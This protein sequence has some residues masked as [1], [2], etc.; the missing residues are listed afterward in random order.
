MSQPMAA[1]MITGVGLVS[2]HGEGEAAHAPLLA[3]DVP[4]VLATATNTPHT[5]HPLPRLE[6]ERFIPRREMRQMEPWQRIGVHA[7]GLAIEQSG[8]KPRVAEMD[9]TVAAGGGERDEALDLALL[10]TPPDAAAL[11]VALADG[12]R[13]TLFLAQLPNLL[14]GSI[15]ITHG[16]AGSSRTM[17]GEEIAGAEALRIAQRRIA[18]GRSLSALSGAAMTSDRAELLLLYALG[19]H[20]HAGPWEPLPRRRGMVLGSVAAFMTLEPEGANPH[21]LARLVAIETDQGPPGGRAGRLAALLSRCGHAAAADALLISTA[22]GA[23][24]ATREELEA[25][26][27]APDLFAADLLGHSVEAAFPAGV[28]LGVLAIQ[29]GRARRVLVTGCGQWRGEAVALLEAP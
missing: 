9:L 24:D 16:V 12:M 3:C 10:T 5:I 18:E 11:N 17:M 6:L 26:P 2:S 1:V 20:L 29:A 14:A 13:P 15:S 25:L 21:P 8:L 7:A 19:G 28:A 22:S 27:R 23:L 4:P